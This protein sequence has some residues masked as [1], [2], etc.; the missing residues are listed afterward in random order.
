MSET[1]QDLADRLL[2]L[3]Q[4]AKRMRD[5]LNEYL[6]DGVQVEGVPDELLDF[7]DRVM[8]LAS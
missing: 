1:G 4:E 3:Y 2:Q 6:L 7:P 5:L 8:E